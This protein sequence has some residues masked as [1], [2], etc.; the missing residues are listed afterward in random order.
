MLIDSLKQLTGSA[1]TLNNAAKA[2]KAQTID[3][4]QNN[5]ATGRSNTLQQQLDTLSEWSVSAD[6]S[7]QLAK[8]Q[9]AEQQIRQLYQQL[10]QLKKQ[11][12]QPVSAEQKQQFSQQL[13]QTQLQLQQPTS[14][15]T[16]A[17]KLTSQPQ[18]Q[19]QFQLN[20]KIDLLSPRKQAEQ[21]VI[22]FS[23]GQKVQLN[24]PAGQ[25]AEANL[26]MMQQEFGNKQIELTKRGQVLLFSTSAAQAH[27]LKQPWQMQGEGIR[28]AAGNPVLVKL[29]Q[30][31][32]QLDLLA[33]Q[34]QQL[35]NQQAYQAELAQ[36]QQKL[37]QMLRQ[38]QSERQILSAKLNS[39]R[40]AGSQQ[41]SE[42]LSAVSLELKQQMQLGAASSL[43]AIMAQGNVTRSL[44]EFALAD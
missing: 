23:D 27:L 10:E 19:A 31:E 9:Q 13:Q 1:T 14:A 38:V 28:V 32:G 26:S 24:F 25:S 35:D 29:Q 20:S 7:R 40:S 34:M 30:P 17:L 16:A 6:V 8:N 4:G 18:G 36:V 12:S 43:S 2:A 15:L 3:A 21:L 37:Q 39:L 41:S 42:Q 5:T 22:A 44:V 11:L 33:Q